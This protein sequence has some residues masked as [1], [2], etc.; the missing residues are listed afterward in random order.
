MRP[1]TDGSISGCKW[2]IFPLI[3]RTHLLAKYHSR[4]SHDRFLRNSGGIKPFVCVRY[5]KQRMAFI[6]L[7]PSSAPGWT[8]IHTARTIAASVVHHFVSWK[9]DIRNQL[10]QV[11][12]RAKFFVMRSPFLPTKPIPASLSHA[13][14]D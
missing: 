5:D 2:E 7:S 4:K 1:S 3:I 9:L 8:E 11:D 10:P 6:R 14:I 12:I 13:D